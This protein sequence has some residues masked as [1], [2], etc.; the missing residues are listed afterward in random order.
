MASIQITE[1]DVLHQ[2]ATLD[3]TNAYGHDG[4]LPPFLKESANIIAESLCKFYNKS[5][6][7][8]KF[9]SSWK[10]SYEILIYKKVVVVVLQIIGQCLF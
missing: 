2:I 9:P 3:N 7:T 5:I 8:M 1:Q 4:V 6:N 10:C